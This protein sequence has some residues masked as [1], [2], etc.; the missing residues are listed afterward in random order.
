MNSW[1]CLG[2]SI[3]S[4]NK[5]RWGMRRKPK[6]Q[7]IKELKLTSNKEPAREDDLCIDSIVDGWGQSSKVDKSCHTKTSASSTLTGKCI[8]RKQLLQF[9]KSHRPA[10]YGIWPKKR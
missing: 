6:T 7:L 8:K 5:Q 1:R 9:D 10:F 4:N 2:H 3:R